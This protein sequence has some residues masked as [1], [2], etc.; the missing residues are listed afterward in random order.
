MWASHRT[1]KRWEDETIIVRT[2]YGTEKR[3]KDKTDTALN[4]RTEK[5]LQEK[6]EGQ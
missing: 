1:E 3:Q 6:L 5:R 2:L 4:S